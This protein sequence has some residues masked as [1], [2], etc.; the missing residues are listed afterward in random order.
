MDHIRLKDNVSNLVSKHISDKPEFTKLHWDQVHC[1]ACHKTIKIRPKSV[2]DSIVSHEDG[3]VHKDAKRRW[4]EKRL[5][6]RNT[7]EMIGNPNDL[8]NL[9][10][11]D[12]FISMNIPFHRL[13][14]DKWREFIQDFCNKRS[15]EESTLRKN[16]VKPIY[17]RQL[18]KI[19]DL[20]ANKWIYIQ[21]DEAHIQRR[22]VISV[23]VGALN[24]RPSRSFCLHIKII[25]KSANHMAIQQAINEAF[26]KLW[27]D[28]IRYDQFRLLLTDQAAYNLKAGANLK[29]GLYSELLH[30]TCVCHAL[31]RV[32]LEM[33]NHYLKA[34]DLLNNFCIV[35]N[36]STRRMTSLEDYI[37]KRLPSQPCQTRWGTWVNFV[38]FFNENYD[39]IQDFVNLIADE[40]NAAIKNLLNNL[41]CPETKRQVVA[42][43]QMGS[44]TSSI[45]ELETVGLK[46]SEQRSIIDKARDNLTLVFKKKLDESL[47]KNPDY[48]DIFGLETH[49]EYWN[50]TFA[51]LTSVDVERSFSQMKNIL[52]DKRTSFTD[53]NFIMFATSH[54]NGSLIE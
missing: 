17:D 23:L 16:Y 50:Y 40:P 5:I 43:A 9:R 33:A 10:L 2:K 3:K 12:L 22:K 53:E 34:Y 14:N 20:V 51:P 26:I 36:K 29:D 1:N 37:E 41:N 52:T 30:I 44:I 25:E 39:G 46:L 8:F 11:A 7:R 42:I 49:E 15:P 31:H 47:A 32:C 24:G 4:S 48:H 6:Q 13:N 54:F 18:Q 38:V 19:R 21:I 28:G 35:F 45:K 27:P